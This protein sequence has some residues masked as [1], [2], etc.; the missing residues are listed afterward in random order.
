ML[1]ITH[2]LWEG[3]LLLPGATIPQTRRS[4]CNCQV[5]LTSVTRDAQVTLWL[6]PGPP[7][8]IIYVRSELPARYRVR[9]WNDNYPYWL[10]CSHVTVWNELGS[11]IN[12]TREPYCMYV[13]V[14]YS[15]QSTV[16]NL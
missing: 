15:Y 6:A 7:T 1:F 12:R 16:Y 11:C 13:R 9:V 10:S 3:N 2:W 4:A 5:C 14:H 8:K